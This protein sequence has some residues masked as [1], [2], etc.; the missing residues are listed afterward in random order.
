MNKVCRNIRPWFLILYKLVI[1]WYFLGSSTVNSDHNPISSSPNIETKI[2]SSPPQTVTPPPSLNTSSSTG[3]NNTH[4]RNLL[5]LTPS[6]D[7]VFDVDNTS[8]QANGLQAKLQIK[9]IA[10]K[11]VV[12]KVIS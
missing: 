8:G 9:N 11:A 3:S 10:N 7:V 1:S 4:S 12:F 6:D 5:G 2:G